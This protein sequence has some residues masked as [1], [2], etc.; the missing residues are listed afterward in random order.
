MA[1]QHQTKLPR[2]TAVPAVN[3]I[4]TLQSRLDSKPSQASA[5]NAK[6][7]RGPAQRLVSRGSTAPDVQADDKESP[8]N[9][10][11]CEVSVV[12]SPDYSYILVARRRVTKNYSEAVLFVAQGALLC[13]SPLQW[14]E[15]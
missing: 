5:S 9:C 1:N 4:E 10:I 7:I 13:A 11:A 8:E 3:H 12:I 14:P 6:V 2:P 15:K